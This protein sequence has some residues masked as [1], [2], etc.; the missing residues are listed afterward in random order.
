LATKDRVAERHSFDTYMIRNLI[1][2]SLTT[3]ICLIDA[4]YIPL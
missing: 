2:I 1:D 3:V 4:C